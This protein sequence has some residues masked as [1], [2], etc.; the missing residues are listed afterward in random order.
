MN[1]FKIGV[2]LWCNFSRPYSPFAAT[3]VFVK[4][5]SYDPVKYILSKFV[6]RLNVT[7]TFPSWNAF[8]LHRFRFTTAFDKLFSCTLWTVHAYDSVKG[9][10]VCI[11]ITELL[12]FFFKVHVAW[13]RLRGTHLLLLPKLSWDDTLIPAPK[14]SNLT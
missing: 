1:V 5:L 2:N 7:Y 14:S 11:T 3:L 12:L 10:C 4:A 8:C 6:M 13:L 9:N